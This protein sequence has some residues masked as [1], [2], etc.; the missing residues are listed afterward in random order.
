MKELVLFLLIIG[1]VVG[2]LHARVD[3]GM[4]WDEMS[5]GLQPIVQYLI[6]AIV[7]A[8]LAIAGLLY[9]KHRRQS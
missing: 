1:G 7:M 5:A 8:G 3:L 4:S 9:L 2:I 6:L